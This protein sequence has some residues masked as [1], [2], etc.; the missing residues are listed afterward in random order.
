MGSFEGRRGVFYHLIFLSFIL[1]NLLVGFTSKSKTK[2]TTTT[3]TTILIV[4]A[5]SNG[6][7][8][9]PFLCQVPSF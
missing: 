1:R 8:P 7:L 5:L 4:I 9:F 2:A 6:L 3:I